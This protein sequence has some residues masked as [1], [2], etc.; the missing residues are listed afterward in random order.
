MLRESVKCK[1]SKE[2]FKQ[3]ISLA[4]AQG[5]NGWDSFSFTKRRNVNHIENLILTYHKKFEGVDYNNG[6][7]GGYRESGEIVGYNYL[8]EWE[9][10]D[11]REVK[12]DELIELLQYGYVEYLENKAVDYMAK[13]MKQ[14]LEK[15][16]KKGLRNWG[17]CSKEALLEDLHNL[18][19]KGNPVDVASCCAL[20]LARNDTTNNSDNGLPK[21][22][23]NVTLKNLD[24]I[25]LDYFENGE[26][27]TIHEIWGDNVQILN[28]EYFSQLNLGNLERKSG[29]TIEQKD[30]K[31]LAQIEGCLLL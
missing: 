11:A 12:E 19:Q 9:N 26:T 27:V 25:K 31:C 6:Y 30:Y 3:V 5:Y 21:I 28:N 8:K 29:D 20:L 13:Q 1:V 2:K 24:G 10:H 17:Y 7:N 22:G 18:I 4:V 15:Q 16:R 14:Q 23:E